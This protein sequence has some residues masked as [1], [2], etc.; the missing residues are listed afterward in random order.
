M[1]PVIAG[2]GLVAG[3]LG[4]TTTQLVIGVLATAA[5]FALSAYQAARAAQQKAPKQNI[6]QNIRQAVFPRYNVLGKAR[7]GGVISFYEA[8]EKKLYIA[9]ILADDIIDGVDAYYVNN[10]ECLVDGSG[11]VTTPPFNNTYG[12]LV[13]FELHFGYTD[14]SASAILQAAFPSAVTSV[15][16]LRGIAYLVTEL[17]QPKV[18]D[19]QTV[20][21]GQVPPIA[22]LVRGVLAYDPRDPAHDPALSTTWETTTNPALLLLYYFTATNGMGL[23]RSLFDGDLFSAV[24]D[25]CDQIIVTKTKGSRKRYEMGGVYSYDQDPVDILQSILD[26]FAGRVFVTQSGLFGLSCDDL[27]VPEI[28]I[29]EDMIVEIEAKRFTGAL[30]E[31]TT[32]KSKFTSEDHGYIEASE[33]ADPWTDETALDRIGREIPYAFDLPYVFRHDQARRLMKKKFFELTPEWSLDLALDFNG[34]ELFGERVCRIVYPPLGIDGTFRVESVSP[35]SDAGFSKI[36]LKAASINPTVAAWNATLEEGTA[37]AIATATSETAAPQTPTDL[38]ALVGDTGA[39]VRA[40][41]TWASF[42]TSKTQE[43]QWKLTSDSSWTT[44]SVASEDRAVTLTGL[45]SGASYDFRVRV[46]DSRYGVSS[47][48]TLSFTATAVVGTTSALQ[49]LNGSAGVLKALLTVVQAADPQAAYIEVTG[50]D[51]GDAVSWSGST[52]IAA[53]DGQSISLELEQPANDRDIY[54]RSIGINGD[55]S[56]NSGPLS[57]LVK[58]QVDTSGSGGSGG[59]S[60]GGGKNDGGTGTGGGSESPSQEGGIY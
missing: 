6:E 9:T 26:T 34:L 42:T 20:Y 32:I 45:T 33:E 24:A 21:G 51:D 23:S 10:V 18:E 19:W 57:I 3:F 46:S 43:A 22:A 44:V 25:Y 37:P 53:L 48:A 47:W 35:D 1:P 14:Q 16:R 54:A 29:T 15:H 49:S 38:A 5:R 4:M 40:L 39:N 41:V 60:G 17:T 52:T 55:V 2:I 28:T 58:S 30:Y 8:K 11:Y 13:R 31:Y 50:V 12:K 56:A 7:V 36:I 59:G 27:D